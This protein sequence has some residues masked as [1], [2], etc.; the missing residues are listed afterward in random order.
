[1]TS[2]VKGRSMMSMEGDDEKAIPDTL[3]FE[4]APEGGTRAWLVA[5]GGGAIFFCT[6]G[7]CNSFGTF[8]QYYITH[9]MQGESASK[10]SWIGSL[11]AFLQFFSGMV[12]GPLFDRFGIKIMRPAGVAYVFAM[13]ILSLCKTYWQAM[14]VQGVLMGLVMGLLQIP[15]VAAVS[16]Y[17]D[18]NRAAALGLAVSGSSIGG[19]IIPIALSKMLNSSSLGFGWSVR[20]I[21]FVTLPLMAFALVVIGPRLPPRKTRFWILSAFKDARFD[22]LITAM[23]FMFIGMFTPFFYLPTYA[24]SQ[25]MNPTLAGYLLAILNAASTFGRI[26]PGILADR[27]GRINTFALGGA[28]SGIIIFC[29]N[30]V[31]SDASLIVYSIFFGFCSGAIISGASAAISLCLQDARNLGTYMGMGMALAGLGGLIGPP[32]NGA[33]VN[34]YSGYFEASMFSGAMCLFGGLVALLAKVWTQQGLLGKN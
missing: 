8:E 12:G 11:A 7:F 18:K 29:M 3:E 24:T 1:M 30:S 26:V 13:M 14:L 4:P 34:R 22:L 9:Q 25:G 31:T 23:F 21:G 15:A 10:I 17:F 19:I 2:A 5:A 16:Q 32:L 28:T 33:I 27:Y 6:L 20:V